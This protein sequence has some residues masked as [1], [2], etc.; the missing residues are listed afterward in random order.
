MSKTNFVV[1]AYFTKN[2]SY[3]TYVQKLIQSLNV[4]RL[5]YEITPIEDKGGWHPNMQHKP[6]FILEMLE[7]YPNRSVV[8]VDAD[9]VFFRYPEYFN[10][11]DTQVTDEVAVHVLDHT[12]Y[13]RKHQPPELLSG[14]IYFRNTQKSSIIVREWIAECKK[15]PMLWDQRALATVLKRYPFHNL[16]EEY[17]TIFDYMKSVKNPV[18]KH[19]QASR[20]TKNKRSPRKKVSKS[21]PRV[22]VNNG[23]VTISRVFK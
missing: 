22:V 14:T 19:Y 10:Y 21:E 16:P 1:V 4:F 20:E 2:T 11:L 18:I 5:P 15:D 17:T 6:T 7:K 13:A 23:V 9:A 8:Y 12:K 3:E